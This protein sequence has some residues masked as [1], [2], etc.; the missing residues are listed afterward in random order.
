MTACVLFVGTQNFKI[1]KLSR[2]SDK[3][4]RLDQSPLKDDF[5]TYGQYPNS[6]CT[7]FALLTLLRA[8]GGSKDPPAL[9]AIK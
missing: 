6:T 4:L 2:D 5:I 8:G 1:S 3:V 7:N 9:Y